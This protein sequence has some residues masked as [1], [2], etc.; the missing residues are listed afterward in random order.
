MQIDPR[1]YR[2]TEVETLLGDP[3]KAK[4]K[5]GWVP[6]I[7]LDEMISEMVKHDLEVAKRNAFL[8]VHGY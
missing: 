4:E 5:L 2:P 3:T 7:T 1:Y 6:E 8:R